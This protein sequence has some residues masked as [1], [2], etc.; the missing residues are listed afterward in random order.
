M[1]TLLIET[2]SRGVRTITLNRPQVHNAFNAEVVQELHQ[3][4]RQAD[5]DAAVRAVVLRGAGKNFS[6][7]AD[8]DWMRHQ[9][10]GGE[11][12]NR[13]G[14][15]AMADMFVAIDRCSKPVL[16]VIQGAALGGGTGLTCAVDIAVGGPKA[17]FGFTE[18]RLGII[19]AVISP[20]AIRRL[21]Y[22]R[23]K[24]HFLLGD[25]IEAQ[26]AHRIG[27]LHFLAEDL[28]KTTEHLLEQLLQGS[29]SAQRRV[30]SLTRYSYQM[31]DPTEF[32]VQ[33]ITAAR[34]HPDGKEGMRAFLEKRSPN[35]Q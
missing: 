27:L 2:D 3:A 29:P 33:Q 9:A 32:T 26:E 4:F 17:V 6:A 11:E 30:K 12:I 21:G 24:V 35:W 10:E 23:A 28:E 16:G 1:Q 8:V 7:G 14:A 18:V 22:S 20:Y 5:E 31:H 13:R 15:R 34:A 25:R 19:P